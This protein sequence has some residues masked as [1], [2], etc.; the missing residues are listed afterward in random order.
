MRPEGLWELPGGHVEPGE[1][2]L[3]AAV[4]EFREETSY[5]GLMM[6]DVAKPAM[7]V[8]RPEALV[9]PSRD[10]PPRLCPPPIRGAVFAYA[11]MSAAVDDEFVP[12]L[13]EHLSSRWVRRSEALRLPL[14]PGVA[15]ALIVFNG[16]R[17]SGPLH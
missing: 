13:T 17:G 2:A 12:V 6:I 11:A 15:L 5:P 16:A 8:V 4:R 7:D 9:F 14:Y 10:G 3:Q 1:D